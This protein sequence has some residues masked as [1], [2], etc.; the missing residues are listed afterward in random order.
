MALK[1][2]SIRKGTTI[3]LNGKVAEKQE[4]INLSKDWNINQETLFKKTLQQGGEVTIKGVHIKVAIKEPLLTS[5]GE[6]YMGIVVVPSVDM[7]F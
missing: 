2:Q 1:P 3:A 5:K 6:K 4:V 7:R